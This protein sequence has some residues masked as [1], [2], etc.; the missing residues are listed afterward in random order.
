[1]KNY[2]ILKTGSKKILLCSFLIAGT[3]S[4]ITNILPAQAL[5][6][7]KIWLRDGTFLKGNILESYDGTRLK[8]RIDTCQPFYIDHYRILKLIYRNEDGIHTVKMDGKYSV[9]PKMGA[10]DHSFYHEF[11]SGQLFGD[12]NVSVTFHAINGYQLTRFFAP[13]IGTGFD[14]YGSYRAVPVYGH[15][16]GYILNNR[17]SPFYFGEAGYGFAWYKNANDNAYEVTNVRG[18]AYWQLGFGYRINYSHAAMVFTLGY[19]NQTAGLNYVFDQRRWVEIADDPSVEVSEKRILRR[20]AFTI[21]I[22]F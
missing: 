18:G 19:Q 22:S 7:A 16:K 3:L 8:L 15:V 6:K 14:R 10:K 17:S 12:E 21:G 11:K 1:M 13:G 20:V 2:K 9:I 4:G 5:S